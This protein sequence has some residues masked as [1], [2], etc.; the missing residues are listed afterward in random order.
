VEGE[1]AERKVNI[2][3][4]HRLQASGAALAFGI[5][6]DGEGDEDIANVENIAWSDVIGAQWRLIQL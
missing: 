3:P 1:G 2:C 6:M 4:L 5:S